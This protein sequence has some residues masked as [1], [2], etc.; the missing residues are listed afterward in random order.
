MSQE[1]IE[2]KISFVAGK[3]KEPEVYNL[4]IRKTE[5]PDN[6]VVEAQKTTERII[7]NITEGK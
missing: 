3:D 5:I 2:F 4:H 6:P 1:I 7:S